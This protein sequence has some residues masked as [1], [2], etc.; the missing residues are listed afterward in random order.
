MAKK[1]LWVLIFAVIMAGAPVLV[2][3]QGVDLHLNFTNLGFGVYL[4]PSGAHIF[5]TSLDLLTFGA[6]VRGTGLGVLFDPISIYWWL[7]KGASSKNDDYN[8]Y[9]DSYYGG[10]SG[11][12]DGYYDDRKTSTA[13]GSEWAFSVFNASVYWNIAGAMGVEEFFFGPSLGF[14]WIFIPMDTFH[15]NWIKNIFSIGLQ[16]GIRGGSRGI[17]YNVFSVETGLRVIDGEGKFFVGIKFDWLMKAIF[18]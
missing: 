14:N 5:E 15:V 13:V 8:D 7:G 18:R 3:A 1:G 6:E 16:G 11:Y 17:H 9:N 2:Q 4:P 12:D 10:S